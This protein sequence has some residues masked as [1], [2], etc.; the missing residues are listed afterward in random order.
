M[1]TYSGACSSSSQSVPFPGTDVEAGLESALARRADAPAAPPGDDVESKAGSTALPPRKRGSRGKGKTQAEEIDA[2]KLEV[3]ALRAKE[4][5]RAED[6][7]EKVLKGLSDM[8]AKIDAL[9][10]TLQSEEMSKITD[11]QDEM[12]VRAEAAER[13]RSQRD[14]ARLQT[15]IEKGKAAQARRAAGLASDTSGT[16]PEGSSDSIGLTDDD[17]A[18]RVDD[19]EHESGM[20][21]AE[22]DAELSQSDRS[23][24][25]SASSE[26]SPIVIAM[27][28][29][30]KALGVMLVDEAFACSAGT[31][32]VQHLQGLLDRSRE[33]CSI[34][35]E[36]FD[37]SALAK[38][39]RALQRAT[40]SAAKAN[41][42]ALRFRHGEEIAEA[43]H[44]GARR[45]EPAGIWN[46]LSFDVRAELLS[47]LTMI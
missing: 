8:E 45:I 7:V 35:A 34:F 1:A 46:A 3:A 28:T 4:A 25:S 16:P 38:W 29:Q 15:I 44:V 11:L 32:V 33:A 31:H 40:S 20:D 36:E 23:A 9:N 43:G 42:T 39:V 18:S 26:L 19:E 12:V 47:E 21:E 17:Y 24:A 41:A 6:A 27:Q 10:A 2:L 30:V 14:S 22:P 37:E 5:A 13:L